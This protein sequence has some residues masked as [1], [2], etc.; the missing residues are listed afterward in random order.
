MVDHSERRWDAFWLVVSASELFSDAPIDRSPRESVNNA[1]R[2]P[3]LDMT[4][5]AAAP[6]AAAPASD[7]ATVPLM[8]PRHASLKPTSASRLRPASPSVA[9][10]ATAPATEPAAVIDPAV[11]P[12]CAAVAGEARLVLGGRRAGHLVDRAAATQQRGQLLVDLGVLYLLGQGGALPVEHGQVATLAGCEPEAV[13]DLP[14]RGA[15]AAPH[16][17]V[18]EHVAELKRGVVLQRERALQ[19]GKRGFRI[20]RDDRQDRQP[21]RVDLVLANEARV[22]R[23]R[24]RHADRARHQFVGEPTPPPRTRRSRCAATPPPRRTAGR[25][26]APGH[27]SRQTARVTSPPSPSPTPTRTSGDALASAFGSSPARASATTPRMSTSWA[28]AP[29]ADAT[30]SRAR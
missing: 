21:R 11:T 28:R 23:H 19:R 8:V 9:A 22:A 6:P 2:A 29:S 17:S 5:F 26:Q 1:P 12:L 10:P 13:H 4:R 20:L 18:A 14:Q 25:P 27:W 3:A 24:R 16:L 15:A 30:T 7:P